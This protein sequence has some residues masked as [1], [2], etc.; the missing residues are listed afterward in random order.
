MTQGLNLVSCIS[1]RFFKKKIYFNW[2]TIT[3]QYYDDFCHTSAWISHGCIC[4]PPSQTCLLPPSPPYPSGLSQSPGFECLASYIK[5]AL[6]I[7]FTYIHLSVLFSQIIPP[8]PSPTESKS[9]F[10]T[11]MSLAALH[12][13]SSLPSLPSEPQLQIDKAQNTFR[14]VDVFCMVL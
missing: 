7:Y 4:V 8:S 12:V 2:R 1:G 10:F 14:A 11:L 3:L 6:V 5:L 9:L 13:G